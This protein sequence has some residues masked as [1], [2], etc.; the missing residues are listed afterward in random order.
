MSS[1]VCA[2]G[3]Y[4]GGLHG[5]LVEEDGSLA[6][7]FSF[8]AHHGCIRAV[9]FLPSRRLLVS[10]GDDEVLRIFSLR[11]MKQLGEAGA[12]QGTLTALC[13]CG[14]CHCLSASSDGTICVWRV[15][16][17][18]RVHV[19]GG[20]KGSVL[21]VASHPSGRM[22]LSTGVDRTLRLW[23]LT[24]GCC[25]FITRTKGA[26]QLARWS[27]DG[28]R[29]LSAV[30]GRVE[31]RDVAA[32]AAETVAI[33]DHTTV[34]L[35]AAFVGIAWCFAT[36]EAA[37]SLALW[38]AEGTCLWRR[39]RAATA[40]VKA[41][42]VVTLP[43]DIAGEDDLATWSR[44]RALA[45]ATSDGNVEIWRFVAPE[46]HDRGP[47]VKT[48]VGTRLTCLVATNAELPEPPRKPPPPGL[49]EKARLIKRRKARR[50]VHH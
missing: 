15:S 1:V 9:A 16:D 46:D 43:A 49:K 34:V 7:R 48:A 20:H 44:T 42:A 8:A 25:S 35:D 30:A 24:R 31:V 2:A 6:L 47:E 4:E 11:S 50:G 40:R 29:Y 23:D 45:A 38:S 22:A 39:R 17:W 27:L 19:L 26:A 32:A 28:G 37:G 14:S 21:S 33:V 12:Q 41:L 13:F 5:W 10:G 18:S 36:T 3:S